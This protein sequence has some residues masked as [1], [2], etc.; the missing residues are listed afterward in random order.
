M[1]VSVTLCLVEEIRWEKSATDGMRCSRDS[2]DC[3]PRAVGFRRG[4]NRLPG[5]WPSFRKGRTASCAGDITGRRLDLDALRHLA[6]HDPRTKRRSSS[7]HHLRSRELPAKLARSSRRSHQPIAETLRDS[8]VPEC[9]RESLGRTAARR[10]LRHSAHS[11]LIATICLGHSKGRGCCGAASSRFA[12]R[13]SDRN[14]FHA[15]TPLRTAYRISSG[16]LWRLSLFKMLL[17]C[18]STV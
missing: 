1:Q 7:N 15:M 18:V 12:R 14:P 5:Y 8:P 3:F 16:T 6:G 10:R 17:L 13:C 11:R 9:G 2:H 4:P